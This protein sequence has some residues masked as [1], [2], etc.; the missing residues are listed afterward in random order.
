MINAVIFDWGGVLIDDPAPGLISFCA[1][2]F[3]VT[4]V[5]FE[6]AFREFGDIFQKGS[7]EEKELWERIS[8][9]L[10]KNIPSNKSLWGDAFIDSYSPKKEIFDLAKE[11]KA[12]KYK[13]G[14]LSNTEKAAMEYFHTHNYDMFNEL[15]FSCVVGMIKPGKEIFN[16]MLSKLSVNAD[17]AVFIDDKE[18]YLE[19]A[20][21]VGIKTILFKSS[22]QVK[23]DL[24][25]LG[26]EI[27]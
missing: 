25:K 8:T 12:K 16:L 7:I 4:E 24:K 17:E 21:A 18:K 23:N 27:N 6:T 2:A 9:K 14:F 15:I 10:K 13:T 1:K 19:G 26:I 5:E 3:E 22:Q 11:L 20:K